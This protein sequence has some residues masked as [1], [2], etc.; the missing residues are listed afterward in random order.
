[1]AINYTIVISSLN[2]RREKYVNEEKKIE[3]TQVLKTN[4]EAELENMHYV[5]RQPCVATQPIMF[6]VGLF[7]F[8]FFLYFYSPFVLRN[9]STDSHKIF[10]NCVF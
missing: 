1:M 6:Y 10:R 4:T 7:L 2:D 3:N 8:I 5:Y 9:Y